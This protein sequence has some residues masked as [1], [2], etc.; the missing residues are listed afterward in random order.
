LISE[1]EVKEIIKQIL[2][3]LDSE[4]KDEEHISEEVWN[5]DSVEATMAVPNAKDAKELLKMKE[6]TSARIG[7]WRTGTRYKT[8]TLLK[9]RLDHAAAVDAVFKDVSKETLNEMDL[10]AV[11]TICRD[12]DEHLTRPDFGR[13]LDTETVNIISQ[14]CKSNPQVQIFVADGLSSTAIEANIKDILPSII[15]GLKGYGID[16]GTSF[17]IKFGRVPVM[18]VISEITQAEVTCLL[19]GERPGLAT[20]ESMSAYIAYKAE[21]GMLEARRTVLSNIHRGGSSSVE[22]GA[23]ISYIIEQM[24]K[25]KASGLDLKL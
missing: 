18:D 22:A 3:D 25:Q 6:K 13:R 20:A 15:Q 16:V 9:L 8:Q 10:F 24:L 7:I 12:K 1:I 14:K 11:K 5:E 4:E 21:V 23:H 17:F 19:I 2:S